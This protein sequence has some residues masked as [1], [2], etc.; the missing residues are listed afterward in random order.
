MT[1]PSWTDFVDACLADAAGVGED[2]VAAEVFAYF[3]D[4][5][6]AAVFVADGDGKAFAVV[7]VVMMTGL[8]LPRV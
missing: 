7:A 8:S 2:E 5:F 3:G 6:E 1:R 4:E